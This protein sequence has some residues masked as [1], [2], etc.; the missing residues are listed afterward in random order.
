MEGH[1]FIFCQVFYHLEQAQIFLIDDDILY[2]ILKRILHLKT[3]TAFK[4]CILNTTFYTEEQ[5]ARLTF[6]EKYLQC[7]NSS[8][9]GIRISLL[10][11]FFIFIAINNPFNRHYLILLQLN[12]LPV[13]VRTAS[14]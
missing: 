9:C 2:C 10:F 11:D 4:N 13:L 14:F 7:S 1:V 3:Y 12:G 8:I 6:Q 5:K